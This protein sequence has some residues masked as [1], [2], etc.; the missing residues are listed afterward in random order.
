M[1]VST[2]LRTK[3]RAAHVT[4]VNT[5]FMDDEDMSA[6]A[7]MRGECFEAVIA[8]VLPISELSDI[9]HILFVKRL[10]KSG[11]IGI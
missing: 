10:C 9:D 3:N 2:A 4:L 6:S 11:A 5:A 7:R 8:L 1:I